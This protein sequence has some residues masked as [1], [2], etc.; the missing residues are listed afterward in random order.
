VKVTIDSSEPLADALRVIG[1]LY[2]VSLVQVD[3]RPSVGRSGT[4]KASQRPKATGNGSRRTTD[5][6]SP[7]PTTAGRGAR[8]T[9]EARAASTSDIRRWALANGQSVSS[10][11]TL[12]AAVKAAYA[13]A[14][15]G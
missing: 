1:A 10:R 12:P 13:A 6:K 11:G 7:K 8:A 14:H 4:A 2:N 9:R 5:R 3:E 15:T